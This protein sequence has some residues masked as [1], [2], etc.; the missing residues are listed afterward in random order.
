MN[1]TVRTVDIVEGVLNL[2]KRRSPTLDEMGVCID[3]ICVRKGTSLIQTCLATET[4]H[5]LA[6]LCLGVNSV[7]K[8]G[9]LPSGVIRKKCTQFKAM[10]T[11]IGKEQVKVTLQICVGT[12]KIKWAS[13][14]E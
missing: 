6:K 11:F 14:N 1:A 10:L 5:T 13:S 9:R 8:A 2:R 4:L 12:P 7:V 3:V